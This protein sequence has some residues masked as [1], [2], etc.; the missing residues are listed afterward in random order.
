MPDDRL[1]NHKVR[2]GPI[3]V[4]RGLISE[5]F[6]VLVGEDLD[7]G[8]PVPHLLIVVVFLPGHRLGFLGGGVG[9]RD[10]GIFGGGDEGR[11]GV[12][13]DNALVP[14][15]IVVDEFAT[16]RRAYISS[17][18]ISSGSFSLYLFLGLTTLGAAA[19]SDPSSA[20]SYILIRE[21]KQTQLI[22]ISGF[23]EQIMMWLKQ[24]AEAHQP[25]TVFR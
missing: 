18:S 3:L 7:V 23:L 22:N 2:L 25:N 12:A 19:N 13:S 20:I 17:S 24:A 21:F 15:E 16:L 10:F 14:H 11:I 8:P 5:G 4:A 6:H 9:I 1:I